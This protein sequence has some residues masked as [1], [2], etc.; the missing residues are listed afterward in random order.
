MPRRTRKVPR[1]IWRRAIVPSLL[2][3]IP[4]NAIKG[5]GVR[6]QRT[7]VRKRTRLSVARESRPYEHG[8]QRGVL[9]GGML[10]QAKHDQ[11]GLGRLA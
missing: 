8:H 9:C 2:R 4:C 1:A 11:V 5:A 10:W 3:T 7:H 6:R